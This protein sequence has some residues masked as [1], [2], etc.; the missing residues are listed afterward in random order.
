MKNLITAL[1]IALML[2]TSPV[3]AHGYHGEIS[4]EQALEIAAKA[5]QKLTFKDLGFKVGKLDGSWKSLTAED[6]KLHSEEENHYVVS[7][8]NSSKDKTIY[9]LMTVSGDVLKVNS[10][11]KF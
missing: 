1:F 8:K 3:F 5:T 10:E 4:A 6:F 7:A 9:F 11:A 2:N